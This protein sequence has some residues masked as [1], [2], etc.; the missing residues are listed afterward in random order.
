MLVW[1]KVR[2][3]SEMAMLFDVNR[4]RAVV[5]KGDALAAGVLSGEAEGAGQKA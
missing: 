2:S 5:V 3:L 4:R 1:I